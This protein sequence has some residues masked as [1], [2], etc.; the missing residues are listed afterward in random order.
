M[1]A[2]DLRALCG[3]GIKSILSLQSQEESQP[4]FC[5]DALHLLGVDKQQQSITKSR[6]ATGGDDIEPRT[7]EYF[8]TATAH[9]LLAILDTE[10]GCQHPFDPQGKKHMQPLERPTGA[11]V[12][13]EKALKTFH[14]RQR[15]DHLLSAGDQQATWA[16]RV[17]KSSSHARDDGEYDVTE[18]VA[19]GHL[20]PAMVFL[21]L[22]LGMS[23][24]DS[25]QLDQAEHDL[26]QK[27]LSWSVERICEL[28]GYGDQA[29]SRDLDRVGSKQDEHGAYF[30]GLN[31]AGHERPL[32]T[33]L[34]LNA[35]YALQAVWDYWKSQGAISGKP[36]AAT[37]RARR[38]LSDLFHC[39]GRRVDRNMAVRY[40]PDDTT[41]DAL[42]LMF[43]LRGQCLVD[44]G[45]RETPRFREGI[46]TVVE[47]QLMNGCWPD[48][49]AT[50]S[51]SG[52]VTQQ[53]S[54]EVA[55]CL[56][57]SVYSR[58]ARTMPTQA[59][60]SVMR[61]A[62]PAIQK[63][64]RYLELNHLEEGDAYG[65]ANGWASDRAKGSRNPE[66]WIT[67][68]AVRFLHFASLI[69]EC[70]QRARILNEYRITAAR[71]R[72]MPK[73]QPKGVLDRFRALVIDPDREYSRPTTVI[74]E[75]LLLPIARKVE[76]GRYVTRPAK[77]GVSFLLFGPPRSGK[78]YFVEKM[79]ESLGWPLV[80]LDPGFFTQKGNESV[81]AMAARVFHD[82]EQLHSTV[83]LFDELD[84]LDEKYKNLWYHQRFLTIGYLQ[85]CYSLLNNRSQR[86]LRPSHRP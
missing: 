48:G 14:S 25:E 19:H 53:P 21:A 50:G 65:T 54:T 34:L 31:K 26:L 13:I 29:A 16:E 37:E 20:I 36:S 6:A 71:T 22:R 72:N 68:L 28:L 3:K 32:A 84:E 49:A 38:C 24:S 23:Q 2:D 80:E 35:A 46:A 10:A 59:E 27:G 57:A 60:L 39:F 41:F 77:S 86:Y 58:A 82:L 33:Y 78:T 5:R 81:S 51:A 44:S 75:N 1:T 17:I 47:S 15:F 45:V 4:F 83:V 70:C 64:A 55:Y 74:S 69:E 76:S 85:M 7:P 73:A 66:T 63:F 30:A 79:A 18:L 11:H 40:V 67:G 42:G 8:P 61:S 43:A 52:V 56:A 9:G 62:V 12:P